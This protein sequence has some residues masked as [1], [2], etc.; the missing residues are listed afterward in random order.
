MRDTHRSGTRRRPSIGVCGNLPPA[1]SPPR[2]EA[3]D[4]RSLSR[5][6]LL[7]AAAVALSAD[8]TL[9]AV[10]ADNEPD[11]AAPSRL[12]GRYGRLPLAFEANHGQTDPQVKF[13]SRGQGHTLF[14]T[15]TDAVFV[16]PQTVVRMQALG[17]DPR[18]T[19]A[20]V[21]ELPART[22]Y[23]FGNDPDAWTTGV[24]NYAGVRYQ[25]IYSGVDLLFHGSDQRQLEYDFVVA[26]GGDPGVIR[27]RFE[28][29]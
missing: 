13:L 12:A 4:M 21:D 7:L 29:A 28:G 27:L 9:T 2:A 17:A 5:A 22:N 11:A 18:A 19:I 6:V 10:H 24:P 1:R 16:L 20:G 23:F 8:R 14:L 15:S 3:A 26:A 25:S